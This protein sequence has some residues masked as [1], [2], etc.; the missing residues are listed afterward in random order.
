MSDLQNTGTTEPV[1]IQTVESTVIP[2]VVEPEKVAEDTPAKT[3]EQIRIEEL[4][5]EAKAK[6][7]RI[8]RLTREKYERQAR[9]EVAPTPEPE[10]QEPRYTEQDVDRIAAEKVARL[11][12]NQR[13][14][15]IASEGEQLFPDFGDK[16]RAVTEEIA[17]FDAKGLPTPFMEVVYDSDKPAAV[18]NYLGENP[19]EVA[20]IAAMSPARQARRI[21]QI[22][23]KLDT[24]PAATTP[25]PAPKVSAA[26][27]P[28][29]PV[30]AA[31]QSDEP[32]IND[33]AAWIAWSNA[34]DQSRRKKR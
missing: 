22:E 15:A 14:N 30:K 26:P 13:A 34:R 16:V 31:A 1:D 21:A 27:E 7:R 2:E 33:T 32:D 12:A 6:Q 20:E 28:I 23:A 3:P 8:D 4:E 25:K 29:K 17:L 11:Q 24:K 19:D 10:Q 18:L 9:Q 5:R